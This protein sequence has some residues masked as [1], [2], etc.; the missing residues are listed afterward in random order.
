MECLKN[1]IGQVQG[2]KPLQ[3]ES[4]TVGEWK[5]TYSVELLASMLLKQS[6]NQEATK[7]NWVKDQLSELKKVSFSSEEEN[8]IAAEHILSTAKKNPGLKEVYINYLLNNDSFPPALSGRI[9]AT[10]SLKVH[11]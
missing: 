2:F 3:E 6:H 7:K 9:R 8:K 10:L 11:E 4:L 1:L 5:T